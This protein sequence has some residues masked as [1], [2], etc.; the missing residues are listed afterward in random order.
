MNAHKNKIVAKQRG[1]Q[2]SFRPTFL[3]LT[4]KPS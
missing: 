2:M 3:G 4:Q 1:S